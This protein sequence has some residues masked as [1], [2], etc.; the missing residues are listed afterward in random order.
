MNLVFPQLV[1]L[2]N[3]RK[4]EIMIVLT[5][6]NRG[7]PKPTHFWGV[8]LIVLNFRYDV[9]LIRGVAKMCLVD[10]C[11][12]LLFYCLAW[13]VKYNFISHIVSIIQCNR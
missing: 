6:Y 13:C 5:K 11:C 2:I 1:L 10:I 9:V 12:L 8:F 4:L 7:F 3:N